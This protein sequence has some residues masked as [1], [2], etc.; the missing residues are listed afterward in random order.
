MYR[1][2]TKGTLP[3]GQLFDSSEGREPLSFQLGSGQVIKGFDDGV[4]G[5]EIG[6][7]KTI[8]IPNAEAYGPINED[9]IINFDRNSDTCR[10]SLGSWRYAKHAPGWQWAGDSGG[11]QGGNGGICYFGCK[12]STGWPGPDL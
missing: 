6:N 12:S 1:F 8:H 2:I 9:M 11:D 7:K 3:D 4:T 5:M 10:H